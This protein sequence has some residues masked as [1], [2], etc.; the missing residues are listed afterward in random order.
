MNAQIEMNMQTVDA[1]TAGRLAA[2]GL[3]VFHGRKGSYASTSAIQSLSKRA[4]VKIMGD[5]ALWQGFLCRTDFG[6]EA[7][8]VYNALLNSIAARKSTLTSAF[9][10]S[11][12]IDIT[13]PGVVAAFQREERDTKKIDRIV[14]AALDEYRDMKASA[15]AFD[16]AADAEFFDRNIP[17]V[18]R[19]EKEKKRAE[20]CENYNKFN[21]VVHSKEHLDKMTGKE[22][23]A[24]SKSL[25]ARCGS[26]GRNV[27]IKHAGSD[28]DAI[29]DIATRLL[30]IQRGIVSV[31][32]SLPID[33]LVVSEMYFAAK[34]NIYTVSIDDTDDCDS[35]RQDYFSFASMSE[36]AA[37]A[38]H[39]ALCEVAAAAIERGV[40]NAF[41]YATMTLNKKQLAV[42]LNRTE[43]QAD[44][45]IDA[46]SARLATDKDFM[47]V[48]D[49]LRES[50]DE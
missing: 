33:V 14:K 21:S 3:D 42:T 37:E 16:D 17:Q 23:A 24:A 45:I 38:R 6:H 4:G 41:D 34:K 50:I 27:L 31:R 10:N 26:K 18:Q 11:R 36:D 12:A 1:A 13:I 5:K 25:F 44:N 2:C 48:F 15:V 22:I 35:D 28:V 49:Q 39:A 46:V 32:P 30:E 19:T 29:Q 40:T 9:A 47:R 20:I 8:F 7:G 43:R